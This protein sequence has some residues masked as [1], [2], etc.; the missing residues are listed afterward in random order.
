VLFA[1]TSATAQAQV[2]LTHT[3][4][5]AARA[6]DPV[7]TD[8]QY[9]Y[10]VTH[11]WWMVT[12]GAEDRS[13]SFL[14]EYLVEHWIPADPS[15]EWLRRRGETGNRKWITGTE[16]EA[17]A[18]GVAIEESPWP[19]ERA[20]GG[21]FTEG[22]PEHGN[23]Q[24]PKPEF[25]SGLPTDPQRLYDRLE[26]DSGGGRE[27]LVYAADA[28]RTGLMPAADRANLLRALAHLPGLD[29]TDGAVDL[30]G[31]TGV[32]LG[33]SEDGERQEIILDPANGEVIG[34]RQVSDS[35]FFGLPKGT[36]TSYSSVTTAV[37]DGMGVKPTR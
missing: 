36:V 10:V 26:R 30:D 27:A 34:E 16:A 6:K 35:M 15:G 25:L 23:W 3:A 29:V 37:V 28:L 5:V 12:T 7:L 33:I 1:A 2:A 13:F 11:A 17:R 19:E 21:N 20:K 24:F 9:R 22:T 8:G 32:A 14:N 4:E 18:A 31:H